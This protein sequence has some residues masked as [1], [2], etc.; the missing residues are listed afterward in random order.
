MEV[1]EKVESLY[2]AYAEQGFPVVPKLVFLGSGPENFTGSFYVCYKDIQYEFESAARA[3]DV[4]IKV[5]AVFG[6][7][8][9]KLSRLVW[10][11]ISDTIYGLV[12]K[13]SYSAII[14]VNRYL[15]TR[16]E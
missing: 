15:Q 6:L 2:V 9:S 14:K 16:S 13:E 11:F 3:L 12:Q 8:F 4:L 5:T 1:R 10:Q 7:P